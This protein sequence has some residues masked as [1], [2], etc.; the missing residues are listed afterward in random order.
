MLPAFRAIL[1]IAV[2]AAVSL[3]VAVV[4]ATYYCSRPPSIANGRHSGGSNWYFW[5]H[6]AITY[7]CNDG[8]KLEGNGR[9]TCKYDSQSRSYIWNGT[10]PTCVCKSPKLYNTI[11]VIL[12][13]PA[14]CKRALDYTYKVTTVSMISILV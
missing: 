12:P 6:T 7:Q 13:L 2:L 9:I 3:Q 4:E 10:P 1:V 14:C 5:V 11:L 8:Y